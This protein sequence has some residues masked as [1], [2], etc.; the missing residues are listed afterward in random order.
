MKTFEL[1]ASNENV[2]ETLRKDPIH[3]NKDLF[4][5]IEIVNSIDFSCSIA[6]DGEWGAGKTFFIKQ[7]KAILDVN[8]P[9]Y[10]LDNNTGIK[11]LW[12][13]F[14]V[15]RNIG[16]ES[17]VTIYYDAWINDNDVD[18]IL[19]LIYEIMKQVG[20]SYPKANDVDK[21]EILKNLGADIVSHFTG[22]EITKYF[23]SCKQ[24]D[25][26]GE[27]KDD[28]EL[29]Q[30]IKA[31][32]DTILEERGNR[33]VFFIDELDRCKPDYA[34]RLLERIKH[35]FNN[36]RVTFIFAMN[37]S[38]LQHTIKR[39]YGQGFNATRY[40][41]RFFDFKL[42]MPKPDMQ[43]YYDL[44]GFYDKSYVIDSI[45][46]NVIE[47]YHFSLRETERYFRIVKMAVYNSIQKGKNNN[48]Y[49]P[50][51]I[52][53]A[54]LAT[55]F[56]PI[57]LGARLANVEDYNSI[58]SGTGG[59]I[60]V[61]MIGEDFGRVYSRYMLNGND[62]FGE[63]IDGKKLVKMADKV[64]EIYDAVFVDKYNGS[65]YEKS[66]GEMSFSKRSRKRLFDVIN[67]FS[68]LTDF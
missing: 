29:F 63:G 68:D 43:S 26:F 48:V 53:H 50:E 47:K 33:L 51:D 40:L 4:R 32:F 60:L 19:S 6:L 45:I 30:Q 18:P 20:I 67:L 44:I 52:A 7:A 9:G 5:F 10:S 56:A 49:Y 11:D 58:T 14:A 12:D 42:A 27:I 15:K 31:F 3:R 22:A 66:V 59:N 21:K 64:Q 55:Y 41:D 46:K 61:D 34:V 25:Y 8:N 57:L 36:D 28:K 37:S 16:L 62:T 38:E 17:V 23:D 35:Y 54:F 24:K 13:N 2:I 65:V 1:A 39:F